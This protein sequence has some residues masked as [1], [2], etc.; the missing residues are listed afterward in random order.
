M[1]IPPLLARS[2]VLLW[3]ISAAQ[4]ALLL[5]SL[6]LNGWTLASLHDNPLLG[7]GREALLAIGA[8]ASAKISQQHEYWRL[9]VRRLCS[10]R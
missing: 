7:P 2:Q 9:A 10:W 8:T 1:C 3:L 4:V 5:A 6:G